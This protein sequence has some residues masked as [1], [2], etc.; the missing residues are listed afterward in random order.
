[1]GQ[2]NSKVLPWNDKGLT[3][4]NDNEYHNCLLCDTKIHIS[5]DN[6]YRQKKMNSIYCINCLDNINTGKKIMRITI[7]PE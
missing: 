4:I 5:C 3:E 7:K 1:M 6:Y 2:R